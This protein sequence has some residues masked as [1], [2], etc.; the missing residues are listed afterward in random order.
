M[1]TDEQP[2]VAVGGDMKITLNAEQINYAEIQRI[3]LHKLSEQR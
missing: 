2:I 1:T 3:C